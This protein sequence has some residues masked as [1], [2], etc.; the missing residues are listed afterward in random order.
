MSQ[1]ILPSRAT[2][3][4]NNPLSG[5]L[6]YFYLEG[7]T[8]P[9]DVY[10]DGARITPH[11]NPVI[12]NAGGLFPAIYDDPSI[13]YRAVLK[14][15]LGSTIADYDPYLP[16][17][18]AQQRVNVDDYGTGSAG[19]TAA[20]AASSILF[21]PSGTRTLNTD[22]TISGDISWRTAPGAMFTGPGNIITPD[23]PGYNYAANLKFNALVESRGTAASP[24]THAHAVGVI[25]KRSTVPDTGA[26]QNPALAVSHYDDSTDP[27]S[28]SQA[29]YGEAVDTDGGAANFVEGARFHGIGAGAK[30]YG[31]VGYAENNGAG[32]NTIAIEAEV[33]RTT[34]SNSPDPLLWTSTNNLDSAFLSTVRNGVKPMAGYLVNPYGEVA[35]RVGFLVGSSFAA[36]GATRP[37]VDYAAFACVESGVSHGLYLRGAYTASAISFPNNTPVR[38]LNAAGSSDL[39]IL[40]LGT[41]NVLDVG[42]E[43]VGVRIT[44]P[45]FAASASASPGSNGELVIERS[46]NT[47]LTFK[48]KGTDGTIRTAT[49][50]LA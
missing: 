41:D 13:T 4:N 40:S 1:F 28:R 38:A 20:K 45:I 9:A 36:Q 37:I 2:D 11:A 5:A 30:A 26:L 27:D 32:V 48:L 35:C 44:K 19:M 42:L 31:V 46:S 23:L 10:S 6:L 24:V 17:D 18:F 12:A 7:T 3:A 47:S 39:N 49:L 50:A 15:A 16:A 25:S 43:A 34:G 14:T 29:I 8:T 21:V 33:A 22:V